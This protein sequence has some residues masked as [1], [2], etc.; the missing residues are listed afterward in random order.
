MNATTQGH[1]TMLIEVTTRS[2]YGQ[3]RIYPV[4]DAAKL[5]AKLT[6]TTTLSLDQLTIAA[7]LGHTFCVNG[8]STC[9]LHA[10]L[11]ALNAWRNPGQL[12]YERDVAKTLKYHDGSA[13]PQWSELDSVARW[14]WERNPTDRA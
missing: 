3:E 1:R 13:R 8:S 14:S 2:A 6:R 9:G 7:Q 4:N 10:Q 5:L 11:R 12:A